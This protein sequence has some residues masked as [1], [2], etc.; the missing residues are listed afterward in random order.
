MTLEFDGI[1]PARTHKKNNNPAVRTAATLSKRAWETRTGEEIVAGIRRCRGQ[2]PRAAPSRPSVLT[3]DGWWAGQTQST[4]AQQCS[5][6]LP[7]ASNVACKARTSGILCG[8][9][10][11][12][13]LRACTVTLSVSATLHL[14][15]TLHST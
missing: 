12:Y 13:M 7:P 15:C 11:G 1:Q 8:H 14:Q 10:S 9:P 6:L 2:N 3:S 5:A 4:Q